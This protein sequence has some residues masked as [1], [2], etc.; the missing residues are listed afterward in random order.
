VKV[1][2][3]QHIVCEP[4]GVYE[5]VLRDRGATIERVELDEGDRLPD[6]RRFDAVIAMGGPMGAGDD[7][8]LP[9]LAGERQ[10]IHDAVQAGMPFWGVCLGAQLLAAS[11]GARVYSGPA[12]EV[13]VLPVTLTR[14]ARDD[15]V[16]AEATGALPT[17]QW[18]GDT[19]D[20]PA[21][22]QLLATSPVY[23]NQAFRWGRAAYGLQFHLEVSTAMAVAWGEVPAY[24]ESLERMLGPGS[25]ERL[26]QELARRS[27]EM[28]ELARGIFAR[29]LDVSARPL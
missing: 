3:L 11:L 14:E 25:F 15:P 26:A 13:G 27:T 18:H 10:L 12:P 5:D 2:V 4:P 8:D 22:A 9:W 6:W 16:F 1:L 17:L 19:F 28:H 29:W 20:L 7:A 23:T 21:G 24:A